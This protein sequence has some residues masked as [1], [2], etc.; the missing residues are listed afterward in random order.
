MDIVGRIVDAIPH[1]RYS[2]GG[3]DYDK[4]FR[5]YDRD[6]SGTLD[7]EEF[8]SAM[9]RDAKLSKATVPTIALQKAF[10]EVD[11]DGTG[12]V[13]IDAFVAWIEADLD[14][15]QRANLRKVRKRRD[16]S[17][18]KR[19]ARRVNIDPELVAKLK[20][21]CRAAAYTAGGVDYRKL[22]K[23]YDRD[24]SGSLEWDEFRPA[25]RRDARIT[26]LV[27]DDAALMAVFAA[28]D[29][30]KCNSVLIEDFEAWVESGDLMQSTLVT[31]GDMDRIRADAEEAEAEAE[32]VKKA[33]Q[34][35]AKANA[36]AGPASGRN[37][38]VVKALHAPKR[39]R[40]SPRHHR[41]QSSGSLSEEVHELSRLAI[42]AEMVGKLKQRVRA[43]AYKAGG[44][45]YDKL[46]R[47]Y[48]RDNSGSL[49]WDEFRPA[50]RRDARVTKAMAP[51]VLLMQIFSV[52][53][54][55]K[56]GSVLIPDFIDWLEG[57]DLMQDAV[58]TPNDL[59][60][61]VEDAMGPASPEAV[62]LA[63]SQALQELARAQRLKE[64]DQQAKLAEL[65]STR[66]ARRVIVD[67]PLDILEVVRRRVSA[68][69]FVGGSVDYRRLF[70]HFAREKSTELTW[71]EFRLTMRS[72]VDVS[73]LEANDRVLREIFAAFLHNDETTVQLDDLVLWFSSPL[74]TLQEMQ[75]RDAAKAEAKAKQL[76]DAQTRDAA[77]RAKAGARARNLGEDVSGDDGMGDDD[78]ASIDVDAELEKELAQAEA[79]A[80]EAEAEAAA[81][82]AAAA[83]AKELSEAIAR[84]DIDPADALLGSDSDDDKAE[85]DAGAEAKAAGDAPTVDTAPAASASAVDGTD[86]AF[87]TTP[88]STRSVASATS[89][90]TSPAASRR[91]SSRRSSRSSSSLSPRKSRA[92]AT[93]PAEVVPTPPTPPPL[94]PK[95]KSRPQGVLC[96]VDED[97]AAQIQA[98]LTA[99]RSGLLTGAAS[100]ADVSS[101]AKKATPP[102]SKRRRQPPPPK[103][104]APPAHGT[105]PRARK[106]GSTAQKPSSS[107]D[108]SRR[109]AKHGKSEPKVS[110]RHR[111]HTHRG[112]HARRSLEGDSDASGFS[113]SG[114]SASDVSP[115][116]RSLVSKRSRRSQASKRSKHSKRSKSQKDRSSKSHSH[117]REDAKRSKSQRRRR[118][119]SPSSDSDRPVV[120]R[121]K[122]RTRKCKRV[123]VCERESVFRHARG[124]HSPHYVSCL[125][126]PPRTSPPT[127]RP[128]SHECE[129]CMLLAPSS[130]ASKLNR[131]PLPWPVPAA[132][133]SS[134]TNGCSKAKACAPPVGS[135]PRLTTRLHQVAPR[136]CRRRIRWRAALPASWRRSSSGWASLRSAHRRR[137][138]RRPPSV[139]CTSGRLLGL[140]PVR[141]AWTFHG[142]CRQV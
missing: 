40:S 120:S 123:C 21:C 50:L 108:A 56:C 125:Q 118:H 18:E 59:Q 32:A 74:P 104:P 129:K 43:A 82:L 73:V 54:V 93:Q 142:R 122:A 76:A 113:S 141:W 52:L 101:A 131:R 63:R 10:A 81:A 38:P 109:A 77:K 61:I 127:P 49:E 55:R 8:K 26:K 23:H 5:H 75:R 102:K 78:D 132:R 107:R 95:A 66:R 134:F 117:G 39:V 37:V 46:F 25:L 67:V 19:A 47:H 44:V 90:D 105:S 72:D 135:Q 31:R 80:A 22:F 84:G 87:T 27:A 30:R 97:I 9:R 36:K 99:R 65:P 94:P 103:D 11:R 13:E 124:R 60:R 70:Q 12:E 130:S 121:R 35:K 119:H 71:E 29:V 20:R 28:L 88:K 110:P 89:A 33:A 98:T 1:C 34:A 15:D 41:R 79:D 112:A 24:N 138:R 83:K 139:L 14:E 106:H 92:P 86:A 2:A 51:D 64:A 91:R 114:R 116:R 137:A 42:D 140:D 62:A 111:H 133:P 69:A 6:N 115:D 16:V 68:A 45:D 58:V 128:S 17:P 85:A 7:F 3:I 100:G 96:D 136:W 48:D 57:D 126:P 53:D 4:L